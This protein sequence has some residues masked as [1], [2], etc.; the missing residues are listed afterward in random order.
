MRYAVALLLWMVMTGCGGS[1]DSSGGN[2]T[3]VI[4]SSPT[5]SN[6]VFSPATA[7]I[8]QGGGTVTV[9]A[10]YNFTDNGSDLFNGTVTISGF[11]SDGHHIANST[12]PITGISQTATTGVLSS[13]ISAPTTVA[14]TYFYSIYITDGKGNQSNSMTG[15]FTVVR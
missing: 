5:I 6:L 10:S 9:S 3:I 13:S 2:T 11:D 15:A 14:G 12:I 7:T 8:G 1:N 4:D